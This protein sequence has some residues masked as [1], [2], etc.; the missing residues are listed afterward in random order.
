MKYPATLVQMAEKP[1]IPPHWPNM[2]CI[3]AFHEISY[4]SGSC[5]RKDPPPQSAKQ[6]KK[7]LPEDAWAKKNNKN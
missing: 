2:G 1:P 7:F 5:G 4:N 3:Y 6:G